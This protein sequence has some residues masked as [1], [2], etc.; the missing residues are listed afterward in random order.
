MTRLV[1]DFDFSPNS[2]D[3]WQIQVDDHTDRITR[4]IL[5]TIGIYTGLLVTLLNIF[6]LGSGKPIDRAVIRRELR[7]S[8]ENTARQLK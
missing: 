5:I 1:T 8:V 4:W 3:K 6:L 7:P 2:G